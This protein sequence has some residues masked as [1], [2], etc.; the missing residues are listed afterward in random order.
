MCGVGLR[1]REVK[2]RDSVFLSD[3]MPFSVVNDINCINLPKPLSIRSC[4]GSGCN[5]GTCIGGHKCKCR[6]GFS[7]DHCE[8]SPAMQYVLTDTLQYAMG[9]PPGD[10]VGLQWSAEGNM[11]SVALLLKRPSWADPIYVARDVPNV[12][13]YL[14]SVQS[15]MGLEPANDYSIITW[16]SPDA[17]VQSAPFTIADPCEY[18]SC[19]QYGECDSGTCTCVNGYTGPTCAISPCMAAGCNPLHST[20]NGTVGVCNCTEGWTGTHCN[21]PTSCPQVCKN[22]GYTQQLGNETQILCGA[23]VCPNNWIGDECGTCALQCK[24][25]AL[26]D[27]QCKQCMCDG[28]GYFGDR[29]ECSYVNAELALKLTEDH[30]QA[31]FYG[32]DSTN[33]LW[34]FN[35]TFQNDLALAIPGTSAW[36]FEVTSVQPTID[37]T[38]A[39]VMFKIMEDCARTGGPDPVTGFPTSGRRL[40]TTDDSMD[41]FGNDTID[42][43]DIVNQ[44]LV[45]LA[46]PTSLVYRGVLTSRAD[47]TSFVATDPTVHVVPD[48]GNK[49]AAAD[50]LAMPVPL[51]AILAAAGGSLVILALL[52]WYFRGRRNAQAK[53]DRLRKEVQL[54]T[55][56]SCQ[57]LTEFTSPRHAPTAATTATSPTPNTPPDAPF[58]HA[59]PEAPLPPGWTAQADNGNTYYYHE[60]THRSSWTRPTA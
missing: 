35:H 16:F 31:L 60:P 50:E 1:T 4:T 36:Q 46:D 44:I 17:S 45:Q 21:Q 29:C 54:P 18:I 49:N 8:L 43:D 42:V 20:C 56:S 23:C 9:V 32:N 58:V 15:D 3:D 12:G 51:T 57:A 27:A 34:R 47:N 38:G 7:G 48:D 13:Q 14:W 6:P 39:K 5:N 11:S 41:I 55:S 19:G 30:L 28:T 53:T 10:S 2:C 37:G 22:D 52:A 25:G 26:P 33:A 59:D 40:L 24:N